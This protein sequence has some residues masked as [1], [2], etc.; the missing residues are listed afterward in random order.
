MLERVLFGEAGEHLGDGEVVVVPPGQL[1][2][3]PWGLLPR[4]RS[5]AAER[6]PVGGDRGCGPGAPPPGGQ[7]MRPGRWC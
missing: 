2:A 1:H 6:G 7:A 3:V 4:L 5:R